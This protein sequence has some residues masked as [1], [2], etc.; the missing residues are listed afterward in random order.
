[1][2]GGQF[3]SQDVGHGERG[4]GRRGRDGGGRRKREGEPSRVDMNL[5]RVLGLRLILFREIN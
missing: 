3:D 2:E 5:I 4:L 1:M